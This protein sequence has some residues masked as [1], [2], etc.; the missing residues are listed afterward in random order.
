MNEEN[1]AAQQ[2]FSWG[3]VIAVIRDVLRRWYLI[4]AVMLMAAMAA[5]VYTDV[6]YKPQYTATTTF[7]ASMGGTGTTTYQNLAAASNVASVFT[8]VL[9]SS[10]L[11]S[12]VMAHTGNL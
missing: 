1:T 5:Y 3:I 9:N 7:V 11:R 12:E 8:E 2:P 6:T 4:A 10:L